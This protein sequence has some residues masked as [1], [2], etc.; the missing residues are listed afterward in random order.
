MHRYRFAP[1]V[2]DRHPEVGPNFIPVLTSCTRRLLLAS[3]VLCKW[4]TLIFASRSM[5]AECIQRSDMCSSDNAYE[6]YI[7]SPPLAERRLTRSGHTT[8][9]LNC[10]TAVPS[11]TRKTTCMGLWRFT[12]NVGRDANTFAHNGRRVSYYS[13][14][15]KPYACTIKHIV[16]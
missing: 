2:R 6:W 11:N 16:T 3:F 7:V 12:G 14:R 8:C 4:R 10:D 1:L 9:G 15:G 13:I 5:C